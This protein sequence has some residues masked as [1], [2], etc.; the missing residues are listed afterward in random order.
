MSETITLIASDGHELSA[1]LAIPDQPPRAGVVVIQEVFGVNGH[2]RSVTDGY[3]R[4]GYLAVAPALFDRA[5]QGLE[6]GYTSEDVQ[7]GLAIARGTLQMPQTLTDVGA[8]ITALRERGVQKVGCVGYCWGGLVASVAAIELAGVLDAAVGYYGGGTPLLAGR[9]PVVPLM[10]HY[11]GADHAIAL[12][13]VEKLRSAWPDVAIHVYEDAEH[14]FNCDQ[15]SAF[16]PRAAELALAR[17]LSFFAQ[18]LG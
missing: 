12:D 17:T 18:H 9:T 11:G 6:L 14:G 1:Y 8:A 3:A 10:E 4:A 16:N 5:E 2:I 13:D 7:R 15:R